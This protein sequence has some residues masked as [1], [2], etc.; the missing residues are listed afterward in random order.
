[1]KEWIPIPGSV[2]SNIIA[3]AL[4]AFG[5][6]GYQNVHV[7]TLAKEV[8]VTTG[9]IYHHFESKIN[10]YR[11]VREE[12]E[13]RIVDRMEGAAALF[14]DSV[15]AMRAALLV[16][17]DAAVKFHVCRLL[18]E[19]D[20]SNGPDRIQDCLLSLADEASRDIALLLPATWR[21][22]LAAVDDQR[23]SP[24]AGRKAL[25]RLLQ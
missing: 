17:F 4:K 19:P 5:E 12:I 15:T 6:K 8:G 9:A 7:K 11:I 24:E 1:M 23:L 13:R 18:S 22:A 16:A 10:L 21:A 2:K 25:E 20:P 14:N 3:A